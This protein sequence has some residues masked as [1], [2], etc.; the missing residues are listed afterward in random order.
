MAIGYP[1]TPLTTFIRG[2]IELRKR[3]FVLAKPLLLRCGFPEAKLELAKATCYGSYGVHRDYIK[4]MLE[5]M[6]QSGFICAQKPYLDNF[7]LRA[8]GHL[9]IN[10]AIKDLDRL[11]LYIPS[12]Q[13]LRKKLLLRLHGTVT[14]ANTQVR[15][16][17][18]TLQRI[19]AEVVEAEANPDLSEKEKNALERK[20]RRID[21]LDN[22]LAAKKQNAADCKA[23]VEQALVELRAAKKAKEDSA[24][25]KPAKRAKTPE[26]EDDAA[27]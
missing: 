13:E 21:E 25:G 12:H 3:S 2:L 4:K 11:A 9:D 6:I 14:I 8:C 24:S 15:H 7:I 16:Q 22:D 18:E 26:P 19:H 20:R 5:S 27:I 10:A 23:F 17:E 1:S